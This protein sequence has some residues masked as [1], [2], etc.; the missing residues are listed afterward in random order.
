MPSNCAGVMPLMSC[1]MK[2]GA[3]A[4]PVGPDTPNMDWSWRTTKTRKSMLSQD[5]SPWSMN[6]SGC[7]IR[8]ST[9]EAEA[10]PAAAVIVR[11]L[12]GVENWNAGSLW[13]AKLRSKRKVKRWNSG[14]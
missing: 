1:W 6:G 9:A 5:G 13:L 4:G 2:R 10:P 12:V 8:V 11:S 3:S 7:L 14:P